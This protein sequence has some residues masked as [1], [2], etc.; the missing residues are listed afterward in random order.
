MPNHNTRRR[1]LAVLGLAGMPAALWAAG[2]RAQDTGASSSSSSSSFAWPQSVE[3]SDSEDNAAYRLTFK[4]TYTLADGKLGGDNVPLI[5]ISALPTQATYA[6]G[7][8]DAGKG[9]SGA[10]NVGGPVLTLEDDDIFGGITG[11]F[12]TMLRVA[13][14]PTGGRLINATTGDVLAET[15]NI[16][17]SPEEPDVADV[18]ADFTPPDS[19]MQAPV[20]VTLEL[21]GK[22]AGTFAYDV[23]QIDTP[24]FARRMQDKYAALTG[25]TADSSFVYGAPNCSL[26]VDYTGTGG[27]GCFFTTAAVGTL[28]LSDD[29]WELRTLR[30]FRDGPLSRTAEGLALTARYYAEAPRLVAGIDARRDAVFVW[31]RTY[32]SHILPC[33]VMARLGFDGA[34]IAHYRRLFVRLERLAAA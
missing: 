23:S 20:T 5:G 13:A 17:T 28:G 27:A 26:P 14:Q 21:D 33:A 32:W 2:A 18:N 11:S 25:V 10:F 6:N 9:S 31:L 15:L 29:C 4:N 1:F 8:K 22:T 19:M 30:A 16:Y 24:S 34:A 12:S 3:C 7:F